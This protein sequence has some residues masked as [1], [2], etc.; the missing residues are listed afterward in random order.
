MLSRFPLQSELSK[1]A[2]SDAFLNSTVRDMLWMDCLRCFLLFIFLRFRSWI[3]MSGFETVQDKM[4]LRCLP[5]FNN[6]VTF[7]QL[8][9]KRH[10]YIYFYIALI[11]I[12]YLLSWLVYIL[13]HK[14]SVISLCIYST[15]NKMLLLYIQNWII[16]FVLTSALVSII[17]NILLTPNFSMVMYIVRGCQHSASEILALLYIIRLIAT[18]RA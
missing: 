9:F 12:V 11:V 8:C 4:I 2:N 5:Y 16:I 10:N 14:R 1:K 6:A 13:A 15:F 17:L 18:G 3:I 7:Q